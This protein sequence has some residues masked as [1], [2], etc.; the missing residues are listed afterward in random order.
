MLVG[1]RGTP[2]DVND[3]IRIISV[4]F[5][6]NLWHTVCTRKRFVER[7]LVSQNDGNTT[8]VQTNEFICNNARFKTFD[9]V[10]CEKISK[11]VTHRDVEIP[12]RNG[13][14]KMRRVEKRRKSMVGFIFGASGKWHCNAAL[15]AKKVARISPA[16]HGR[17][18][19]RMS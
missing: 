10:E 11:Y 2:H 18:A 17:F 1:H 13:K 3:E 7:R 12:M 5:E 4:D 8:N 6:S 15:N 19:R 16:T 14:E 9:A